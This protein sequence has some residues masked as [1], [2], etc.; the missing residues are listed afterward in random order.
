ME[1]SSAFQIDY[2]GFGTFRKA[3]ELF[4]GLSGHFK[5][6]QR[7]LEEL[8]SLRSFRGIKKGLWGFHK[9]FNSPW[10]PM[11]RPETRIRFPGA[12]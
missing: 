8:I 12:P 10:N 4:K 1:N 9:R 3:Q 11:R 2:E 7:F 5:G 6:F